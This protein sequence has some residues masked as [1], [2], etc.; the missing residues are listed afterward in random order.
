M[1]TGRS[2]QRVSL[3]IPVHLRILGKEVR[4]FT[5]DL[6]TTG[7]RVISHTELPKGFRFKE[8]VLD[9]AL[10]QG[11]LDRRHRSRL[12]PFPERRQEQRRHS[13]RL[14]VN[15]PITFNFKGKYV[16]AICRDLGA[17]GARLYSN[18]PIAVGTQLVLQLSFS[19]NLCFVGF[20]GEVVY[21]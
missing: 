18:K 21:A 13:Q 20:T 4:R 17:G 12:I 15:L 11:Q 1:P 6:S 7:L 10:A 8:E 16:K 19:R 2:Q 14:P 9:A 3:R 5:H